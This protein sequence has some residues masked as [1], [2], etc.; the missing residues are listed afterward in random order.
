M[1]NLLKAIV[2]S[3]HAHLCVA[4]FV[5]Y[6]IS[7]AATYTTR[8]E[9][10]LDSFKWYCISDYSVRASMFSD[11]LLEAD[12]YREKFKKR[13]DF[14]TAGLFDY[15]DRS[16]VKKFFLSKGLLYEEW[17]EG[18]W[19]SYL[20]A[21]V[22]SK[23]SHKAEIPEEVNFN[24]TILG[25]KKIMPFSEFKY[26]SD[27]GPFVS[28]GEGMFYIHRDSLDHILREYFNNL[29]DS[30]VR[31][32]R[33]FHWDELTYFLY[34]DVQTIC[35]DIFIKRLYLNK[36]YAKKYFVEEGLKLYL[37][38]MLVMAARMVADQN[39][40]LKP[41]EKYQR[42]LL[43]GLGIEPN[44]AMLYLICNN[45][46]LWKLRNEL[47]RRLDFGHYPNHPDQISLDQISRAAREIFERMEVAS[48]NKRE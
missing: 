8:Y 47:N 16:Q 19:R 45:P 35:E 22:V 46:S 37:P 29:W 6:G 4:L 1:K 42:A 44:H 10:I 2:A 12:F 20:L 24:Y 30:E 14:L 48:G 39:S 9:K 23:G 13:L 5:L 36:E 11:E 38:T 33:D 28:P 18:A 7:S 26:G 32:A 41:S 3:R 27:A 43:T 25:K 17:Q 31:D 21:E 15:R 34:R 40:K